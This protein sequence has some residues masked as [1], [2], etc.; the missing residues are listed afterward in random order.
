MRRKE[1][2]SRLTPGDLKLMAA[3]R[4]RG[5]EQAALRVATALAR[6]IIGAVAADQA[7]IAERIAANAMMADGEDHAWPPAF[8][9]P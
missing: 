3:A 6:R 5:G 9:K 7:A 1:I 8:L 2:V 4:R